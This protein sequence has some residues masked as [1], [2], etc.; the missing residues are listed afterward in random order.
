MKN[1]FTLFTLLV[2]F[3]QIS[4]SQCDSSVTK[5]MMIGDSWSSFPYNF[6]SF[7]NNLDRYGYTNVN[8]YSNT[9]NL[10]ISG[11]VTANFL[12]A[13]SKTDVQNEL[14]AHPDVELINLSIGGNDILNEWNKSMDSLTTDSLIDAMVDRVDSIIMNLKTMKPGVKI[15]VPGYD[16]ANFEEVIM[17]FAAPTFHLFYSR[18]N[19]MGKPNFIE[20]N[21]LLA[22]ASK[23]FEALAN[24]HNEVYYNNALGLMQYLYGQATP[25]GVAPSGTYPAKSVPL[26]GGRLDYPTPKIMMN[27]YTAFRDCFHLS[28]QGFDDFYSYHFQKF[29]WDYLRNEV[30]SSYV[31]EGSSKDGGVSSTSII[32]AGSIAIGNSGTVGISKGIVSFNT[33]SLPS[34]APIHK[35]NI[36]LHRHNHTGTL[37]TFNKVILEVKRGNFG[38]SSA[39]EFS[40]YSSPADKLDTACVYGSVKE[41]GFWLRIG[42]PQGLLT[43]FN[44]TGVTQFRISM[45]DTTDGSVFYFSTGDSANKPM[46]DVEFYFPA[47]TEELTAVNELIIYPNPSNSNYV[48][49]N[50]DYNFNGK[51][52]AIDITGRKHPLTYSGNQI[53]ISRLVSGTYFFIFE[54]ETQRIVKRFVKID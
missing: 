19:G 45:V 54:D 43:E 39:V 25:L 10:S 27:D 2:V 14:N 48:S 23:K 17:T 4:F 53:D 22:K 42:V 31:S 30:D 24:S 50:S 52:S 40:D 5:I 8:M 3:T 44:T 46:M 26:P 29:Y 51:I 13:A 21:T 12:T 35:A 6:S 11:A 34:S 18:W 47:S 7:E 9:T 16:Y 15:Y 41:N 37:P 33:A 38:S 32:N 49:L 20:I 36:F 1:I 28:S